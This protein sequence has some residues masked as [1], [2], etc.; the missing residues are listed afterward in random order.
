MT[1]PLSNRS[2]ESRDLECHFHGFSDIETLRKSGPVVIERG[3]G[4]RVFDTNGK[5]YLEANS[6]LWNYAAGFSH[7]ELIEVAQAQYAKLPGYHAFFGRVSDAAVE[8]T[9]RVIDVSPFSSGKVFFT[10][11]GSEANDTAVKMLWMIHS[12]SGQP[13]RRKIISRVNGYHGVTVV[14]A[15]MTG[16]PY[17]DV[18]GLPLAGFLHADCPHYWRYAEAGESEAAFTKRMASN[19]ESLIIAEGAETIAGFFAEPVQGAGGVIIPSAGYFDAIQPILAK[20]D[21]PLVADEVITGFGRTGELW[22]SV[23]YDIKPDIIIASKCI[24]AGYFPMGAVILNEAMS[25]RLNAVSAAAEEFPHGFTTAG[26]PVGCAIA[27]K[28]I[29]LIVHGGLLENVRA[30]APHFHNC[31]A[32]YQD[33]PYIGEVRGIGL[34]AALE[35]VRDKQSKA[36]FDSQLGISEEIA[37]AALAQGLICRPLGQSIVLCPPFIITPDEI[38]EL[39]ERLDRALDSAFQQLD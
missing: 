5:S 39:F 11:S 26:H 33:H 20:Y 7:P 4:I 28:A 19:L 10:N 8:L 1:Q 6:G 22:G 9:E 24:T 29:D 16:K 13:E 35:V 3:E 12:G 37:N 21:I 14:A 25:Q 38:D 2:W 32:R 31:L 36:P 30:V 17:N 15:S 34:M 23:T 27:N 18:F